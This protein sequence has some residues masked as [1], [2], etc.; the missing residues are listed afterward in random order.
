MEKDKQRGRFALRRRN[1]VLGTILAASI[2]FVATDGTSEGKE[3][4]RY[5]PYPRE[6]LQ[7]LM[8]HNKTLDDL[9]DL[10]AYNSQEDSANCN[11]HPVS[12]KEQEKQKTD[13]QLQ[14]VLSKIKA[15]EDV[16][17]D[18]Y[19]KDVKMYYPIYK[20]VADKYHM[21]WYLLWIVHENET[22]ASAGKKGFVLNSYYKGA[23]QR[24]PNIWTNDFVDKAAEGLEDLVSIPQ[25]HKDDWKE[26]AAGAK[27]LDRNIEQYADLGKMN[28]I[29][30]SLLLYSA[31][32]QAYKR[33]EL[34]K[35]Y[36]KIFSE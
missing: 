13:E 27:I 4:Y 12:K 3:V 31:D 14:S 2:S 8:I 28:A 17:S 23:M 5:A 32:E 22:G 25:R 24:D 16:F 19:I 29:L 18:K 10:K 26:I 6:D 36:D 34:Y 15:N 11:L 21:D 33:F 20:A 1:I 7:T 35:K 30:N 9:P